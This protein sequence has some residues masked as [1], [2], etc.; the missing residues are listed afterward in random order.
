MGNKSM[1]EA[2]RKAYAKKGDEPS[3]GHKEPLSGKSPV[4]INM[5]QG[6][7]ESALFHAEVK[8][9]KPLNHRNTSVPQ[10]STKTLNNSTKLGLNNPRKTT[11]DRPDIKLSGIRHGTDLAGL[12]GTS[13]PSLTPPPTEDTPPRTLTI[14]ESAK[15]N[16]FIS[17]KPQEYALASPE[18]NGISAQF[19]SSTSSKV[20]HDVVIGLDFGTSSV[21]AVVG[22]KSSD[23]AFA[24][25][26]VK[27]DGIDAYLLPSRIWQTD[28]HF[29]LLA[30]EKIYRDLKLA[31]LA[32][33]EAPEALERATAFLAIIIRHIRGWL[34][35]K[36]ADIYRNTKISWKLVLGIP[37]ESYPNVNEEDSS[38]SRIFKK[39]QILAHTAWLV[40]GEC[41]NKISLELV[42][43]V[44]KS[45][46]EDRVEIALKD[47]EIDVVPELSAQIYGFLKSQTFDKDANN[48]F[49]IVD[50]GAGTVDTALFH[51][52]KKKGKWEFV[53][54]TNQ[55]KPYGVMNLHRIRVE[56]WDKALENRPDPAPRMK[57]ILDE[58]L[59]PTDQMVAIPESLNEYFSDV[60]LE[61]VKPETHPDKKYFNENLLLQVKK[62]TFMRAW[63]LNLLSKDDLESIP[64][65]LCGGGSRMNYFRHLEDK[66]KYSFGRTWASCS[67]KKL[68]IPKQLVAPNLL[69]EDYDRLSVAYGLSFLD[70]GKITR[71]LPLPK[72]LDAESSPQYRDR[73]VSKDEM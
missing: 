5:A 71:A 1:E 4:K 42:K 27:A 36:H 30:G 28:D 61:F 50:I 37:A 68:T 57:K 12:Y 20:T 25:P 66:M 23:A 47:I 39:F 49:L 3:K 60:K 45:V 38:A 2:M 52:S 7:E 64:M 55:V 21:K 70:V 24:V 58:S 15:P 41:E 44:R 72:E 22:D 46:S 16:P 65:F 63:E 13:K 69:P 53:Y 14:T 29:S 9:V 62:N 67:V 73:Y 48:T 19:N 32:P 33:G 8:N 40:A 43:R 17:A 59:L 56:W 10:S 34:F 51:V 6:D 31:I 26:F 54:Y 35:S 11:K 18:H